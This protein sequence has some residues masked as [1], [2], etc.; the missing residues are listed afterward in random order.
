MKTGAFFDLDNTLLSTNTSISWGFHMLRNGNLPVKFFLTAGFYGS[1]YK[2][3]LY[4]FD[5]LM[6]MLL[7]TLKGKSAKK[8]LEITKDYFGKKKIFMYRPRMLQQVGWHKSKKHEIV[9]L[10]QAFDFIAKIFAKDLGIKYLISSEVEIRNNR[11]T[12]NVKPCVSY[13]K[14]D[15]MKKIASRLNI[16]LKKS[17]AYTDSIG[18][19]EMLENVGHKYVINPGFKLKLIAKNKKWNIWEI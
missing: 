10:T 19:V 16:D 11:F 3:K 17:Y 5:L 14:D 8:T 12:G 7:K 1:L 9:I 4:P 15:L 2:L 13:Q 18:D 6:K